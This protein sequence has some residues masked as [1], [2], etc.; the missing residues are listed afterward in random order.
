MQ[1]IAFFRQRGIP[2]G[3][4]SSSPH[5]VI[6]AN[7]SALDAAGCFD[8]VCSAENEQ[9]GKP[10]PAVYISTAEQ[11][12]IPPHQILV[13]EDSVLGVLA[14]K[15]AETTCICVP[16]EDVAADKRLGLADYILPSLTEFDEALWQEIG[17][18]NGRPP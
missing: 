6:S 16:D 1:T 10:H 4:A 5:N 7:I 12:G 15:T 13:F 3:V 17:R 18:L 2:L 9:Q 8:I 14:A 11:L